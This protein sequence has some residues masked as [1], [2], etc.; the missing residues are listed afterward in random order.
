METKVNNLWMQESYEDLIGISGFSENLLKNHFK[1]YQGYVNNAN[2]LTRLLALVVKG[3]KIDTP[4]FA[5]L[6]RRFG[7]EFNGM[8]LHEYYFE[9]L[10]KKGESPNKNSELF[11]K[12]SEDFESYDVWEK[13]FKAIGAMR[14]IGW[15]ILC[16]D[17]KSG[18]LMSVWISEHDTGHLCGAV[19]LLVMD[20]FEHAYMVDYG[21]KKAD[22]IESFFKSI[23]WKRV[24]KRF[25]DGL[26]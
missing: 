24:E 16:M 11:K 5:E 21:L 8:R 15:A 1:L 6:K 25:M 17:K 7:W 13:E 20:V 22:Y 4:E 10:S 3:G 2:I 9:N 12:L 23:D 19:P 26:R 18:K 14:G